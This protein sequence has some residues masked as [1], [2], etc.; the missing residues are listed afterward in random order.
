MGYVHDTHMCQYI[1]PNAMHFVTGT[2]TD[3]AGQTAGTICKHRAAAASTSVINI[4]IL[5]PQNSSLL[6]GSK[7]ASVEL[8]YEITDAVATSITASMNKITRGVDTAISVVAAVPVTQDLTAA[9]DAADVDTHRLTVTVTT[10]VWLDNDEY[11][12]AR[13]HRRLS[14]GL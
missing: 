5:I 9:T 14:F 12:L 4:P 2:W 7:L 6:K 13:Y 3:E 10:P 8:E 1:P 11:F